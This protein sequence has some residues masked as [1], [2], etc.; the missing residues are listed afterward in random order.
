MFILVKFFRKTSSP[1]KILENIDILSK[2]VGN[3][4]IGQNVQENLDFF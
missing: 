2:T 4:D 3:L 1:V